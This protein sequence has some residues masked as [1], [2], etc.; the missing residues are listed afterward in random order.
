MGTTIY[1]AGNIAH[2]RLESLQFR[3][4]SFS[5][6]MRGELHTPAHTVI[7]AVGGAPDPELSPTP[8]PPAPPVPPSC[9]AAEKTLCPSLA[10]AGSSCSA[11]VEK[12]QRA[13][14]A[15][16]CFGKK[17]QRHA[18]IKAFCDL[19][20]QKVPARNGL[21]REHFQASGAQVQSVQ[22]SFQHSKILISH[23]RILICYQES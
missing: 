23:S 8:S 20:G 17:K 21:F 22:V 10:G 16:E 11:C 6:R 2:L 1:A 9:A 7:S 3:Y 12:N 18:F 19:A 4:P 15:A 14:L 13:F 5:R